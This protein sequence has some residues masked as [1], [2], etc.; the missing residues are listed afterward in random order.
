VQRL[1]KN[2]GKQR[3]FFA[4]LFGFG[5]GLGSLTSSN[6]QGANVR[7]RVV[8]LLFPAAATCCWVLSASLQLYP[9][10]KGSSEGEIKEPNHKGGHLYDFFNKH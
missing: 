9:S 1:A 2:K 10:D 8:A 6:L 7:V 4:C 3:G 5:L